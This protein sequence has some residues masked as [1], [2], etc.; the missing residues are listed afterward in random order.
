[1]QERITS[2]RKRDYLIQLHVP[3]GDPPRNGYPL[4][5]LLDAPTTWAP[6]QQAL[7]ESGAAQAVIV[8]V[9]WDDSGGVDP[10]LR[11]RDFTLPARTTPPPPRGGGDEWDEDGDAAAFRAFLLDELQ[12]RMLREL[13]VDP[14]RQCLAGHS[15]SG[16]FVLHTLL[17]CPDRFECFVA[18]S[19]SIWWDGARIRDEATRSG[20]DATTG[21]RVLIT[22]GSREQ[23]VGPEKPPSVAGNDEPALLGEEHMVDNASA[24]AALLQSQGVDC[25]FELFEDETH[26]SVL[27][28]AMAAALAFAVSI[29]D[30]A[31]HE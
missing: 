4:V 18:A 9:G 5:W 7:G 11:R 21:A 22:V 24:F 8:G 25:R 10:N 29:D 2:Q 30:A 17:E 26:H 14:S 13:P 31:T 20:P 6:M 23:S 1:M 3:Q 12:P 19:P 15:L 28:P 16:L 27:G